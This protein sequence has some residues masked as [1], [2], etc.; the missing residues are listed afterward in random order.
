VEWYDSD[1]RQLSEFLKGSPRTLTFLIWISRRKD[2]NN[3]KI[4]LLRIPEAAAT[5]SVARLETGFRKNFRCNVGEY[6]LSRFFSPA[7][8]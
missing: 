7:H 6:I 8:I 4:T 1:P 5:A 3:V 2:H